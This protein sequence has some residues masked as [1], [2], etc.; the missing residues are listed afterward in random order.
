VIGLISVV[1]GQAGPS[2]VLMLERAI[3]PEAPILGGQ[4]VEVK[5]GEHSASL[6]LP[7]DWKA[8]ADNDLWVHFHTAPWFVIQEYQR[9]DHL[10]PVAVFNL[11]QGSTTYAKPFAAIGSFE[12]WRLEFAK[13]MGGDIGGLHFTSF[14]AGYGAVRNLVA[15]PL[16]LKRL[17]TVILADSLYASLVPETTPRKVLAEH[18]DCWAGLRDRAIA[19]KTT[20][21]ITTSQITPDTYAGTW[22]VALALVRASGGE[23]ET[24]VKVGPEEQHLLRRFQRGHWFAWSYAGETAMAHMTH[25]RRLAELIQESRKP[26]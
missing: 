8:K 13:A 26:N 10:G 22:E 20:W 25:A 18:V 5:V 17:R 14:S 23:M 4:V 19:G 16:V 9:A 7:T 2:P 24:I 12:P 21:I 1:V 15:D 11:G 3:G 6:F